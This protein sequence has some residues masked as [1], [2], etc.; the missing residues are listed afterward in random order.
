M[1][2][3]TNFYNIY[4]YIVTGSF[5][6]TYIGFYKNL[7]YEYYKYGLSIELLLTIFSKKFLDNS[8]L[9]SFYGASVGMIG[10]ILFGEKT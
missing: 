10:F 8:T 4:F 9:Y 3:K 7:Y 6:G 1:K 5:M 2:E